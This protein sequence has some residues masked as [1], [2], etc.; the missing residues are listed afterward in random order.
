MSATMSAA[1]MEAGAASMRGIV[2]MAGMIGMAARGLVVHF[3]AMVGAMEG[4]A[5]HVAAVFVVPSL[6][7]LA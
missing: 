2:S 5:V 3:M 4:A 6:L 7:G 1:T